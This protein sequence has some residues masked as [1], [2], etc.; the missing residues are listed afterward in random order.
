MT[1]V[2]F[3]TLTKNVW[4]FVLNKKLYADKMISSDHLANEHEVCVEEF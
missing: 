1:L 3:D 4:S 2:I